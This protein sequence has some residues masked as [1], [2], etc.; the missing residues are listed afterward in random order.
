MTRLVYDDLLLI[1]RRY[2]RRPDEAEDVLQDALL[3]AVS[4]GRADLAALNNRRWLAG[5]IRNRA[6]M[7]ARSAARRRHR[8]SR[9]QREQPSAEPGQSVDAGEVLRE[10][11]P[12]LKAVAA[13]ALS[14]HSRREIAY[15]LRL[16]D[17]ALRR[18]IVALKRRLSARGIPMPATTPGLRLELSYGRI[19]DA[20]LPMLVRK[21]G[22]FASHDPDG[23]LFV[24]ARSQNAGRRQQP[25]VKPTEDHG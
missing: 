11:P 16:E 21:G 7:V 22:L 10:L 20:L 14:G 8:E 23:H 2:S 24:F 9:W 18:R 25:G 6:T 1:A 12:A 4:A 15:L 3:A 19:R 13:L 5:V 17:T